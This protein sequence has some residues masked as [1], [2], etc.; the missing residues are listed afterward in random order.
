MIR[1]V[2][3]G[4]NL[5]VAGI[6]FIC[7]GALFL[8]VAAYRLARRL[9]F[10]NTGERVRGVIVGVTSRRLVTRERTCLFT[11]S[12]TAEGRERHARLRGLPPEIEGRVGLEVPLIHL[13]DKPERVMA[14]SRYI[15][16]NIKVILCSGILLALAGIL[17][18]LIIK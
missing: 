2:I 12:Y 11:V 5:F 10:L 1:D 16:R 4:I 14:D 8:A 13:K 15:K 3:G 17:L 6:C 18:I 9:K 7:A